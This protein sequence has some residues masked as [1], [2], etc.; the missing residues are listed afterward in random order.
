VVP[1]GEIAAVAA[2]ARLDG[3]YTSD[4]ERRFW[5]IHALRLIVDGSSYLRAVI[6]L[7]ASRRVFKPAGLSAGL[8]RL[9]SA[10]DSASICAPPAFSAALSIA[11]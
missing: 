5:K 8:T 1:V 7:R 3:H 2:S 11:R 10:A 6:M 4:A 9:A